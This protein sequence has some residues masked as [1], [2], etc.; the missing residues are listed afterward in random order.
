[1][2]WSPPV[3]RRLALITLAAATSAGV[4]A[5]PAEA[6]SQQDLSTSANSAG[7]EPGNARMGWRTT[8]DA[9]VGVPPK[10][11]LAEP[12]DPVAAQQLQPQRIVAATTAARAYQPPGVLGVDVSSHQ[13]NVD[14]SRWAAA[15]RQFTFVKATEGT[16]Y[17]NPYFA[18]QYNGAASAGLLR[19]AYHFANPAG[20][21][22]KAQARYFVKNGGGWKPDGRTLP[23]VL[24]I[25]YN[26]HGKTCYGLSKT[27]MKK[28][29]QSFTREYV[30][31]TGRQATIYTTTDWWTRCTGGSKR[32]SKI[33]PLWVA[34]YGTTAPGALPGA[35]TTATFWQ[36]TS[37]PIDQNRFNGTYDALV[38]FA[39]GPAAPPQ[40]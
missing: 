1:M 4:G 24:D 10:V 14:W 8:R 9:A 22:G 21:S 31:L 32:F 12:V 26:P 30:K 33:N 39:Q 15:G 16:S 20:K 35:W 18:G 23:G 3:R 6:D 36:Y 17:T 38:A 40:P 19:G 2:L 13:K 37:T 5:L 28:W 27:K 34:R 29:I 25:E 11:A 7:L